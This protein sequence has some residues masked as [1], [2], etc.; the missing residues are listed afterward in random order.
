M[1][2][3]PKIVR[4]GMEVLRY[5]TFG[6]LLTKVYKISAILTLWD[7]RQ[8][9]VDYKLWT[10]LGIMYCHCPTIFIFRVFPT[11]IE[12]NIHYNPLNIG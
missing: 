5:G 4:Y 7:R 10:N 3:L 2:K 6:N 9:W 1:K 8:K 11:S 12:C